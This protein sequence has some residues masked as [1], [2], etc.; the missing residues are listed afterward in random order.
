[1]FVIPRKIPNNTLKYTMEIIIKERVIE[2]EE[3]EGH[4]ANRYKW[5]IVPHK[6]IFFA[7]VSI[8]GPKLTIKIKIPI[9]AVRK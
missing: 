4:I 1:M 2:S 9:K 5:V 3:K 7:I 8:E 6:S